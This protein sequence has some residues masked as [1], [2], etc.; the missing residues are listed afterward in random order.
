MGEFLDGVPLLVLFHKE[1]NVEPPFRHRRNHYSVLPTL[2]VMIPSIAFVSLGGDDLAASIDPES[3]KELS[4]LILSLST[5]SLTT[6]QTVALAKFHVVH[7][8]AGAAS[9][10][11]RHRRLSTE[12]K[13]YSEKTL[14]R[15]K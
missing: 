7:N 11:K 9:H 4:E 15:K 12:G 14:I 13:R 3:S 10:S 5:S 2:I 6:L 8:A 1:L